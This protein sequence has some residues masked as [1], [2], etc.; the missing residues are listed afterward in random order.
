MSD[1][2]AITIGN[3]DGLHLGHRALIDAC[4]IAVGVSGRVIVI[5]FDPHPAAILRPDAMPRRL[6]RF[7][8]RTSVVEHWQNVRVVRLEPALALLR[9]TPE[10][11][12]AALV[13]SYRP[14]VIVEGD[15]FRFGRGRT[16]SIETLRELGTRYNFDVLTV[17]PVKVALRDQSVVRASSSLIRWLISNGRVLDATR[18]LGRPYELWCT[19]VQGEKR[20]RALGV[21]T[22]NLDHA[23]YQLPADGVYAGIATVPDGRQFAAAISV[24]TKPTFGE[25]ARVC[26]AHLI[27]YHGPLD[28]YGWTVRLQIHEWLREQYTYPNAEALIEQL[29]RD[30]R[31]VLQ[32]TDLGPGAD[33]ERQQPEPMHAA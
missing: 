32:V 23:D 10:E 16:G 14:S 29:H 1:R 12:V 4:R 8:Q 20:G 18:L 19:V 11:Y 25:A 9:Q 13:Q 33:A 26:E 22:V 30:N 6:S 15:D 2:T 7:E 24:G 17:A 31:N 28:D 3:F 21:P 5:S 27:N